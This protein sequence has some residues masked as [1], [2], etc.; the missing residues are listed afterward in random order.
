MSAVKLSQYPSFISLILAFTLFRISLY[1]DLSSADGSLMYRVKNENYAQA[2]NCVIYFYN[3]SW[4]CREREG[5]GG[6]E[7]GAY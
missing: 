5:V 3:V 1:S 6:I 2:S 4:K 7:R